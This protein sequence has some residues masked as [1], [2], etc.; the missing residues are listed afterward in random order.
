MKSS[1]SL[2]YEANKRMEEAHAYAKRCNTLV[3]PRSAK[4]HA[5]MRRAWIEYYKARHHAI[6]AQGVTW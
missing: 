4:S 1:T 2:T 5:E 6:W 3:T